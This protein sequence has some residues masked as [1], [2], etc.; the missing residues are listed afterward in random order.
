M[1]AK[2]REEL[3][4]GGCPPHGR[5]RQVRRPVL[6]RFALVMLAGAH[7]LHR[8]KQSLCRQCFKE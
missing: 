1:P 7:S 6:F 4:S 3:L 5:R 2:R 8:S